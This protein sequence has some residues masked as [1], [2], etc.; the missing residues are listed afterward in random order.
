MHPLVFVP[1]RPGPQQKRRVH[2]WRDLCFSNLGGCSKRNERVPAVA[3]RCCQE[4]MIL[5]MPT[6]ISTMFGALLIA[7]ALQ[8][9]L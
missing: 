9:Q 5:A 6:A 8:R 1:F 7:T 3:G 4:R 2:G